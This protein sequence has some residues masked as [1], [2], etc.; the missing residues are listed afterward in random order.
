MRWRKVSISCPRYDKK[1]SD[2][3]N[4]KIKKKCN[5]EKL[6]FLFPETILEFGM[7]DSYFS[8]LGQGI[9]TFLD[10]ISCLFWSS[11]CRTVFSYPCTK[12]EKKRSDIPNSKINKKC[13]RE[14]L[15]F[16]VLRY[17]KKKRSDIPNSR[18]HFLFI[19]EFGISDS[20]FSYLGQGILTFLDRISGLKKRS[21]IP[22][23]KINKKCNREKLVFLVPNM[24]NYCRI[25]RTPK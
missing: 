1:R 7:S 12:Y 4:S 22:N 17:E 19:L 25:Y 5:R 14:M 11:V 10:C 16:L 20:Y 24:R 6:V 13:D 9:L 15:V 3:L 18:L 2:I 21:D 23:S 8:Y